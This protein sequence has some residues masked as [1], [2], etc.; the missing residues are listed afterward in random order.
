MSKIVDYR[1]YRVPPRWLF[2][3]I[4]TD[5]GL[6]GWGEPILE[7]RAITVEAAVKELMDKYVLGRDPEDIEGLWNIMYRSGFYRGGPVLMSAL[8]GIDQALWDIKGKRLGVPVHAL[9]GG[10]CRDK[11]K[12]YRWVGGDEPGDLD[13]ALIN[14]ISQGFRA[15]KM[16][17]SGKLEFID[18]LRVVKS[19]VDRI[20]KVREIIGDDKDF[21]VDFH[22]RVSVPMAAELARALEPFHPMFIEEPVPPEQIEALKRIRDLVSTPIAL[23]ERLYSRWD[24]KP[25]I[26]SNLVDIV[27]PDVSHAG[28]ITEVKKIASYAEIHGA[29]LAIHCPLGP[30]ALAASLQIAFSVYNY[31]IQET[32]MGIHYNVGVEL[33]DYV[34]NAEIFRIDNGYIN[35]FD[36]PGLGIEMDEEVV[37]EM[38]MKRFDWMNPVWKHNDGSIAEW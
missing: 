25:Y 16:N 33:T 14:A 23:G 13:D 12:V 28:G 26:E 10:K 15:F 9:L 22:G 4:E 8:S 29:L 3:K 6:K 36:L 31:L 11:V 17:V 38:S 2:V 1:T 35:V 30:I 27:Q 34:K 32:S 19:I 21:A 37:E 18:N 5:D 20:Q 7:G 24:F